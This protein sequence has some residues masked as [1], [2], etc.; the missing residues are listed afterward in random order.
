MSS[1]LDEVTW[2]SPQARR[3]TREKI[4]LADLKVGYPTQWPATG[5]YAL[6]ED[7]FLENVLAARAYETARLWAQ[8]RSERR[9]DS[10]QIMVY[11][12]G[13]AGFAVARL[14][15]P[16]G[17]P[18][19]AT[20]SIIL[21]AASLRPPVLD[22]D[23]PLEVLM[24]S[25]GALVA[26]EIVHALDVHQFDALGAARETWTTAD[27]AGH[28]R[29]FSCVS[30][31]ASQFAVLEGVY[32]DGERTVYENVADY[33]GV[34]HTYGALQRAL[35]AR[36]SRRGPDGLSRA[37]RFFVAYAQSYCSADTPD[38]LRETV[39]N[40]A[41]AVARFRVNAPLSNLP[42]FARTFSCAK[43]APMVRPERERCRAW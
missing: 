18:D 34:R 1:S 42:A 32:L 12:S 19:P 22:A 24:G 17:Y 28:K 37:Q 7:A 6:R 40:D 39:R 29:M 43:Q 20:N 9:R 5:S 31:Q 3:A 8:A 25:F 16:N 11:P 13:A 30:R 15:I 35:G 2:M 26:H 10:W 36:M 38:S 14:A 21:P 4:R 33:A 23:A 41:H 27:V